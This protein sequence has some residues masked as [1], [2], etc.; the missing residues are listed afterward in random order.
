MARVRGP[1]LRPLEGDAAWPCLNE[2]L[3]GTVE[4]GG[5]DTV[6]RPEAL[7][8]DWAAVFGRDAPRT[9]EI[10]FNR[11]RFLRD[12]ARVR[13]EQ[14]HVGI[15][16]R[17]RYAWRVANEMGLAGEPTNARVIW[18][19]AKLVAPAVFGHGEVAD[20]FINFPDP[21]W[22]AKHAK[23]RLVD[24]DFASSLAALLRPAGR[25]YIKSDVPAIADE[26]EQA[27][28]AEAA[29]GGPTEFGQDDLPLSYRERNCL[30][31]G[32]PIR[33]F[34]CERRAA[35]PQSTENAS[36]SRTGALA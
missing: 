25:I 11:G 18:G 3:F 16:I 4:R 9:L 8:V 26:I 35:A 36:M 2:R 1:L 28:G 22:K 17:R 19:D 24:D 12:L 21:W 13:P 32:L 20:I 14:D 27:L 15:E 33:R 30:E 6:P 31:K 34:F 23:R 29:L 5:H 7:P 10:G